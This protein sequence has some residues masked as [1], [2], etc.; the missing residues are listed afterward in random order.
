MGKA[1]AEVTRRRQL[2]P[3]H[4]PSFSISF[5]ASARN[6]ET[7]KSHA[8]RWL[9]KTLS[10]MRQSFAEVDAR[11]FRAAFAQNR[12]FRAKVRDR[13]HPSLGLSR[14]PARAALFRPS[15][16]PHHVGSSCRRLRPAGKIS[17]R[18]GRPRSD[19]LLMTDGTGRSC[20]CRGGVINRRGIGDLGFRR[21]PLVLIGVGGMG[22]HENKKPLGCPRVLKLVAG[23][24]FEPAAFRL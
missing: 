7:T 11:V 3:T 13:Q 16:S 14:T 5:P 15:G 24:G 22:S 4:H 19:C 21:P 6:S 10:H 9:R 20:S 12:C 2:T 17:D 1:A 18:L 23:A 8:N